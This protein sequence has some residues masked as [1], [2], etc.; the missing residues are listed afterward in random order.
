MFLRKAERQK[1]DHTPPHSIVPRGFFCLPLMNCIVSPKVLAPAEAGHSLV[2]SW[3]LQPRQHV[4]PWV[5]P[6]LVS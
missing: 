5:R 6:N 1:M 4:V 2:E 3:P